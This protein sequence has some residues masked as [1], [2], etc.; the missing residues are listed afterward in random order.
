MMK[1]DDNIPE[2]MLRGGPLH[3]LGTR[4][5]LVRGETDTVRLGVTL[6]LLGWGVLMLLALL[7]GLGHKL[8]SFTVIGV[9]Q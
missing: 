3:W 8:F 9:I 1:A 5:R 4:R 2:L 6:G 7:Q